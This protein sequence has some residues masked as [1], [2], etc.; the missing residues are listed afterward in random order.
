[1]R[2]SFWEHVSSLSEY[3]TEILRLEKLFSFLPA[4]C[5][6][7]EATIGRD[8]FHDWAHKYEITNL[9]IEELRSSLGID[10]LLYR[11]NNGEKIP[12][13]L[14]L[15]YMEF[16][17]NLT[18]FA[19]N[20]M[21]RGDDRISRILGN[22]KLNCA[23]LNFEIRSDAANERF[24]IVEKNAAA[25]AVADK[26][27]GQDKDLSFKVIEYNHFLLKGNIN[28]KKDI[29]LALADKFEP[30]RYKLKKNN[31]GPV[32]C[33]VGYLLNNINIR[34]NNITPGNGG[35]FHQFVADMPP[36]ELEEW[37][38][39]TY[40]ILLVALLMDNYI[41]LHEKIEILKQSNSEK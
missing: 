15:L 31:Y 5:N 33:D 12:L 26:Y 28:R 1:M 22:I 32:E 40:D 3:E 2:K 17:Y 24:I 13:D 25:T 14:F 30:L 36:S 19:L 39:K 9:S 20:K 34:H 35:K 7:L 11:I 27:I 37:Y 23:R 41:N 6:S 18:H 16:L 8:C 21:Y 29:L 38:D 10:R 4:T